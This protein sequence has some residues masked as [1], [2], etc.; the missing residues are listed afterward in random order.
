MIKSERVRGG[1]V[2]SYGDSV[3]QY[4]IES[5]QPAGEVKQHCLTELYPC[6]PENTRPGLTHNG[7]CGFPF[8]L[9][10]YYTFT[11]HGNGKFTYTVTSPYCG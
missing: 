6:N 9:D 5:D 4:K 10:S 3:Y 7:A 8:G 11:D 1:Q 2:R